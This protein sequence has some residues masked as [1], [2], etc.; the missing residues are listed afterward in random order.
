MHAGARV[1][2]VVPECID[3][4][5]RVSGGNVYD[6]RIRDRL[7]ADGWDVRMILVGGDGAG[8]L[9]AAL[10]QLPGDALVLVDGLLATDAA[11]AFAAEGARLR[12]V[13]LAHM[14]AADLTDPQRGAYGVARRIIATSNWTR[15][16]LIGRDAADP[17]RIVVAHPGT[18]P[19]PTTAASAS[20]ARLLCVGTIAPHKGQDLLIRALADCADV[21][22]WTCAM[23]GS[24]RAAP[25]FAAT[26]RAAT[27][28]AGLGDRITFTG[29]LTGRALEDAWGR[30]D[31]LVM[32]SR[33]ESYGMVV[34]E[35]L[36]RGIPVLTS[37]AGGI[38]E[39][40]GQSGAAMVV[41]PEDPW[42]LQV[43]LRQWW[44]SRARREELKAAAL[45]ARDA[46]R[47]WS[48]TA[49]M[50]AFA[51]SEAAATAIADTEG[52]LHGRAHA[53]S[54]PRS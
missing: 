44:A 3:D 1:F 28:S 52:A 2:F 8:H 51:L 20:G 54:V 32:P 9:A 34:A 37:G 29:V 36:A 31:L 45:R 17:H 22:Q 43:V 21:E 4:A 38:P 42:A 26:L 25:D 41:P 33:S 11:E 53:G 39:A 19:A 23:V 18:D 47:P 6:R 35:A 30:A 40:I 46:A 13:A 12:L 24:L 10:S 14:V 7:R 5:E 50:V 49:R 15:T 16:E 48:A 27:E